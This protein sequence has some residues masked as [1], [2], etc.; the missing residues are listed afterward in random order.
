MTVTEDPK[1]LHPGFGISDTADTML[2]HQSISQHQGFIHEPHIQE[3]HTQVPQDTSHL[4]HCPPR[5]DIHQITL[6]QHV[7]IWLRI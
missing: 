2:K 3:T 5:Q 7:F 1:T 4:L 6:M